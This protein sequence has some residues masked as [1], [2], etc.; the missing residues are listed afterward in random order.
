MICL[1]CLAR[2]ATLKKLERVHNEK[3][4]NV[5]ADQTPANRREQDALWAPVQ[6]AEFDMVIARMELKRHQQRPHRS[7]IVPGSGTPLSSSA[8]TA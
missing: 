3:R 7:G 1:E 8:A 4:D 6:S 5:R 2:I